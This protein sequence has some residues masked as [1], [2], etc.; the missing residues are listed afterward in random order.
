MP[1]SPSPLVLPLIMPLLVSWTSQTRIF[2][3]ASMLTYDDN[4][5]YNIF[6]WRFLPVA[7][8]LWCHH[9]FHLHLL[10]VH[11]RRAWSLLDLWHCQIPLRLLRHSYS[12]SHV[13]IVLIRGYV[14]FNQE[15]GKLPPWF[16]KMVIVDPW[17]KVV[18][19][20][21]QTVESNRSST[22]VAGIPISSSPE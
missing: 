8:V 13:W 1:P 16:V 12:S 9:Q 14:L 5:E 7:G 18:R 2:R 10:A 6:I 15:G 3:Q 19:C 11:L 17:T 21:R 22:L 4:T 20:W